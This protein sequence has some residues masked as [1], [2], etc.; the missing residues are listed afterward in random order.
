MYLPSHS[1]YNFDFNFKMFVIWCEVDLWESSSFSAF[2]L[3]VSD[4][5]TVI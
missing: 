1:Q 4:D 3:G 5:I 2:W